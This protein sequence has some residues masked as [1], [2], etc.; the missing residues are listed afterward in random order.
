MDL[1][2]SLANNENGKTNYSIIFPRISSP[3]T[4]AAEL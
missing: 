4:Q 1:I 3:K 2:L